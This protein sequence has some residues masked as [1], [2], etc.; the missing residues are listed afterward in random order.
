MLGI[1]EL[2]IK[3]A[4]EALQNKKILAAG[5]DVYETEPVSIES[6]LLKMSNVVTVPHIGSATEK[7][8]FNMAMAAAQSLVKA[9]SGEIPLSITPELK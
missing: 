7:T 2:S 6:P 4:R 3:S 5:L 1:S 9:L 8:R